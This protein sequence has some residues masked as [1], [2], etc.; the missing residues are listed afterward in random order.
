MPAHVPVVFVATVTVLVVGAFISFQF[1]SRPLVDVL[2]LAL[3]SLSWAMTIPEGLRARPD[4][5]S[6]RHHDFRVSRAGSSGDDQRVPSRFLRD[7]PLEPARPQAGGRED[8]RAWRLRLVKTLLP[9]DEGTPI[10]QEN[11]WLDFATD[12]AG[13]APQLSNARFTASDEALF[14]ALR[15]GACIIARP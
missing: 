14:A 9:D 13:G 12:G 2:P 10:G 1:G 7:R 3:P 6:D 5:R 15:A 4:E 11:I 8:V